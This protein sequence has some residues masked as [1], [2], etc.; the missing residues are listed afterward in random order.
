V[1][2]IAGERVDGKNYVN[3]TAC[4]IGG[5]VSLVAKNVTDLSFNVLDT[6]KT[7][8]IWNWE[9]V[10]WVNVDKDVGDLTNIVIVCFDFGS[11]ERGIYAYVAVPP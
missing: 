1:S 8:H 3:T 2:L 7:V 10:Y 4:E 11:T 5:V 6:W 9:I